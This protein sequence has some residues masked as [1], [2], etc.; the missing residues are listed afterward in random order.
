MHVIAENKIVVMA[1]PAHTLDRLQPLDVSV[2]GS[3]KKAVNQF[4]DKCTK[5]YSNCFPDG[6]MLSALNVL[7]FIVYGYSAAMKSENI[8]FGLKK[9]ELFSSDASV[10]CSNGLQKSDRDDK[11]V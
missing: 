9:S 11:L 10:G 8:V 3:L 5:K 2:F 1:L 4:F 7:S 6:A